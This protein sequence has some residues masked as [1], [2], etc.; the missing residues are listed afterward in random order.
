MPNG[1]GGGF[2]FGGI[3]DPLVGILAAL[4]DAIIAFLNALVVALVPV[5][6]AVD[7]LGVLLSGAAAPA[8]PVPCDVDVTLPDT[9]LDFAQHTTRVTLT[10]LG[11]TPL[12]VSAA[13]F[14]TTDPD[15]L[16]AAVLTP[17]TI[18]PQGTLP[19]LFSV[20]ST[21]EGLFSGKLA[22]TTDAP[23][24]EVLLCITARVLPAGTPL[25]TGG[26]G[27]G[28]GVLVCRPLQRATDRGLLCE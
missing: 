5:S 25:P 16:F 4:I 23:T 26:G 14:T 18:S 20:V 3:F 24:P 2:D 1:D 6:A 28:G 11:P 22:L 15:V 9:T 13:V 8:P 7:D 12:T 17:Q 27:G 10:N 19:I 21:R